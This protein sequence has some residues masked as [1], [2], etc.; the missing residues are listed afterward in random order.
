MNEREGF[1]PK[2]IVRMLFPSEV[3][4]GEDARDDDGHELY[5]KDE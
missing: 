5:G 3:K 4:D 2:R 1:R